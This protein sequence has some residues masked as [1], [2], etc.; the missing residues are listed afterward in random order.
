M[1]AHVQNLPVVLCQSSTSRMITHA[2]ATTGYGYAG[3]EQALYKTC[4]AATVYTSRW[5]ADMAIT[6]KVRPTLD[7]LVSQ[8]WYQCVAQPARHSTYKS[9]PSL[10][11]IYFSHERANPQPAE[12]MTADD[13][14]C[15]NVL[16][17]RGDQVAVL[18]DCLFLANYAVLG[19]RCS[20]VD[21]TRRSCRC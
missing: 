13:D 3:S 10:L 15:A 17:R 6:A 8:R 9:A 14:S 20:R 11:R 7:M 5:C 12:M 1:P 21:C 4:L 16:P 19:L 2:G 18:K